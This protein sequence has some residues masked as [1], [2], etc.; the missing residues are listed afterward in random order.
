[1][2]KVNQKQRVI[3]Y[4]QRYGSITSLDAFRDLG[5]TRL[6]AVIC[7]LKKEG[8]AFNTEYVSRLN[9]Y[10][11]KV[12]FARYSLKDEEEAGTR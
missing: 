8:Y 2:G 3:D 11:E 5:I 6:A 12:T 1:M 4:I 9:R 10:R 7:N